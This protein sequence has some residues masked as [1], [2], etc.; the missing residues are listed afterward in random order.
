MRKCPYIEI[1]VAAGL[2]LAFPTPL[3]AEG[4]QFINDYWMNKKPSA[5]SAPAAPA[6][7][8]HRSN[9]PPAPAPTRSAARAP[10]QP[11][12]QGNLVPAV[13]GLPPDPGESGTYRISK[14][15]LLKIEI[16]QV[17]ELSSEERV[18]EQGEII[19]PL[20]GPVK[21]GGLTPKAAEAHIAAILGKDYLQNPQVD[22]D[23]T[24]S[25]SQQ[26]TVMGSV[27]KPGVFPISGRTTLL[28]GIALAEGTDKLANEEE[29]V[30]FRPDRSGNILA[31]VIDLEAIQRGEL[32]D[33]TLIGDDRVVV[34]ESGSAAFLKEVTD[35]LRGFVRLPYY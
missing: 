3:L 9:A 21:V 16:F 19:M 13:K 8:P 18:N 33:P 24:E 14:D 5:T 27:N 35:T 31:Y 25:A 17:A 15:D 20:I 1:L 32:Q 7:A 4:N 6:S 12:T 23:V 30:L 10:V 28:Q 2:A 22:I 11:N 34:P 29:V 26:V